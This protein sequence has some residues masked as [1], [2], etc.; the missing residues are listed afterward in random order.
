M[1]VRVTLRFVYPTG[2]VSTSGTVSKD[3]PLA[4]NQFILTGLTR[5]ILGPRRDDIGDLKNIVVEVAVTGGE[6]RVAFFV[7]SVDNGTGDTLLLTE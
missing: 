5:D 3:Y 6:G 4:A 1:T 2:K 7:S